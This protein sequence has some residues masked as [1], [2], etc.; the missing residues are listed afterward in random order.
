M[1]TNKKAYDVGDTVRLLVKSPFKTAEALVTVERNGVLFRRRQTLTGPMPVVEIPALPEFYPNAYIGVHLVRGRVQAPP[2]KG[3][4]LGGPDFRAGYSELSINPDAHRLKVDVRTPKKDYKPGE[5]LVADV[6]VTDRA[7][8]PADAELAFYAVDEGVLMLTAYKTPDPLPPFLRRRSLAVF[9]AESREGLAHVVSMKPGER[10][11]I[12]GWEVEAGSWDKGMDG[13]G[14][15]SGPAGKLR[16]DFRTTAH[17]EA[18]KRTTEGHAQ[19][20]F[21][22]PDNL[23]SFRLMAVV[24]GEKDF[25]GSGESSVTTS[26]RLMARPALPRKIRIGDAFEASVVLSSKDRPAGDVDVTLNAAGITLQGPNTKR[27]HLPKGGTVEARFPA[28]ATVPG[29]ASLEFALRSDGESDRVLMKREVELPVHASTS[30]AYGETSSA[31]AIALGDLRGVRNDG[32]GLTVKVAPTALVGIASS[33]EKLIE[34]PYGCTE[35]LTSKLVPLVALADLARAMQV[36]LPARIPQAVDDAVDRILKGQRED[37]GFAFWDDSGRAEPWLTAYVIVAL[38]RVKKEGYF[39]PADAI[40]SAVRFLRGSLVRAR[41]EPGEKDDV[42]EEEEEAARER[43]RRA[44]RGIV[45]PSPEETFAL[46]YA[47][48]AFVT[49]G[50]AAIGSPDPGFMNRLYDA[51]KG[52]PLFARALLLHAMAVSGM[53]DAQSAQ[54]AKEL[55]A[56]LVIGPNEAV[57]PPTGTELFAG[58]LDSQPRTTALVLRALLSADKQ[59]ALAPRL[60]RG[61]LGLRRDGGWPS[62]Q[63]TAWALVALAMYREAQEPSV[64]DF[65]ARAFL[66]NDL[67]ARK[68]FTGARDQELAATVGIDRVLASSGRPL[69]F[70]VEG[71]GKLFYAAELRTVTAALPTTAR[72]DGFFLQKNMRAMRAEDLAAA[73]EI[74]PRRNDLIGRAG[75]LVLVDLL[76]ESSEPRKQV[77]IDDPLPAG[78]EGV[79]FALETATRSLRMDRGRDPVPFEE[80]GRRAPHP[81][82]LTGIGAVV[83]QAA[84]HREMRDDRVLTFIEDLAPGMYHFRYVARATSIGKFVVPPARVECMYEPEVSGSTPATTFEVVAKK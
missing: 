56:E 66:G 67:L 17:F 33:F 47:G 1:E 64:S 55:E 34:Y 26:K 59:H 39:V 82:E 77:V 14:G 23:T 13:G 25:F 80:R 73:L 11:P 35:Q 79:D 78:L 22:L 63:D 81:D 37:G 10:V 71:T 76:L 42:P 60:A 30:A 40:D 9:T 12:L 36:H 75:E 58:M 61:L 54:L 83:R 15:E 21:K 5:E 4:D 62:T 52:K 28:V 3:A 41:I 72:D 53:S 32:G 51:R 43:A 29:E 27:V 74:L 6:V 44:A 57:A 84:V 8:K 70:Q 48:A 46:D 18:G 31:Q 49:D 38:E 7:G 50:L 45:D 19:I 65:E 20:R 69:T 24:A 16:A 68:R 2:E